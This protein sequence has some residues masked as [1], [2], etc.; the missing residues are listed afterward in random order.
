MKLAAGLRH[1]IRTK[2]LRVKLMATVLALL[3]AAMSLIAV[4]SVTA[5]RR[6]LLSDLDTSLAETS[7]QAVESF[8]N[9][10]PQY[11]LPPYYYG[12]TTDQSGQWVPATGVSDIFADG[13]LPTLPSVEEAAGLADDPYTV[14]S[15]AEPKRWRVLITKLP[16]GQYGLVAA[17][18][19][20]ADHAVQRLITINL[21]GGISVLLFAAT[22]GAEL[23]RRSMRPLSQ[24]EK[25][26]SAIAA[27][28]LSQRVPDP[29]PE[30]PRPV[31]EVGSLARS[32]NTM[33]AQIEAAFTAQAASE[34][35][36][37]AAEQ[38]ARHSE[39][40]MRRFVADA[41]HELR[42][43]LTTIRGFAELYR[44]GAVS[45]REQT[46]EV[47]QRIENE[48]ARMGLLVEDLLLLARLDRERP[49]KLTPVELRVLAAEAVE[50]A[51]VV[52]PERQVTLV[53]APD[54]GHL[55][56]RGD[57]ARLRQVIGNLL[58]NALT[59]TPA[60]TPVIVRLAADLD[61]GP[62]GTAIVEI[63]DR[64]PGLTSEQ[65]ERV[66][67]RFYR[68]DPARTRRADGTVSTGLGLAIVAALVAAHEGVVEVESQP[69]VGATFRVRLPLVETDDTGHEEDEPEEDS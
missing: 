62:T 3:V 18:Q 49:L 30:N 33:L 69:G 12:A 7:R 47:V 43:P 68:A 48:A 66:F 15:R 40:R 14:G 55:V 22:I 56:V 50:A 28:D 11:T 41:S 24:I 32:L 67:E 13:Q 2:P 1:P 17:S 34:A 8:K 35:A 51:R 45:T 53:T 27:G 64:G 5:L 21:F 38:S 16:T 61:D 10:R 37:R 60:G 31:T 63:H 36:A 25:T 9:G 59:H 42:T 23:I 52:A 6:Y 20:E 29:E 57:D 58:S 46:A 65:Q 44:Q 39:E 19:Y 54:S 4:A 26:A